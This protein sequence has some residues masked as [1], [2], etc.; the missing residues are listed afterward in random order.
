MKIVQMETQTK[1]LLV[2]DD[3]NL[4]DLLKDYLESEDFFVVLERDGNAGLKAYQS[5]AFDLCIFD[6]MMPKTDGL[7][8]AKK[9]R[10]QDA[11]IPIIFLTAK[12]MKEDKLEG[13]AVGGDDYITKPFDEEELVYRIQAILKRSTGYYKSETPTTFQ[14]GNFIF[15]YPNQSLILG[16]DT[17]R[18]TSR[19]GDIL[20]LLCIHKNRTLRREDALVAIWGEDDYFHGR[21]FDVFITKLRKYLKPDQSVK[22]ENIH[23]VGFKLT[24]E[25]TIPQS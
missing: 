8:L 22:I 14:L 17:Q 11:R 13:F 9:V 18:L 23:G 25:A 2:E 20:R 6:V 19:E 21:S 3:Q 4:G 16:E 1:I 24:D 15:D 10:K 5:Q 12:S 7:T